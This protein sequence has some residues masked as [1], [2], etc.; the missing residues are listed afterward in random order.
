MLFSYPR[1][2]LPD[3]G[4]ILSNLIAELLVHPYDRRISMTRSGVCQAA[5]WRSKFLLKC[6]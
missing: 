5:M 3:D 6:E 4:G 1:P 2:D